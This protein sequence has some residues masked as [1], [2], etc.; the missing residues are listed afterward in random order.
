MAQDRSQAEQALQEL[1]DVSPQVQRAV[2]CTLAGKPLASATPGKVASDGSQAPE[3][4]SITTRV[5][6][7][8]D[9]A[10]VQ[11]DREPV[12]QCEIGTGTGN[13][14]VV[15]DQQHVIAAVTGLEP[16]VGLV[17]YDLKTALR[18]VRT[19]PPATGANGSSPNGA[20]RKRTSSK[21][22]S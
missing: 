20:A 21:E 2:L 13:L 1:V 3:L 19:Q 8:A 7:Q 11:L 10:R 14:F 15:R 6:E 12:V 16:T 9:R 17:F 18:S 5:L 22:S 4:A